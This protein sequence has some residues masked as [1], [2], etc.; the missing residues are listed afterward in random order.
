MIRTEILTLTQA[1]KQGLK[2]YFTGKPCKY[3][4]VARRYASNGLCLGCM[5]RKNA[6]RAAYKKQH[7]K[8]RAEHYRKIG[9]AY[10][11][12]RLEIQREYMAQYYQKHKEKWYE[13]GKKRREENR[14]RDRAYKKKWRDNNKEY[15]AHRSMLYAAKKGKATLKGLSKADFMPFYEMR[16]NMEKMTGVKHHVDH[17]VPINGKNVCG[18]HVPWN[19]QVIP[20]SENMRKSNRF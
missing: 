8:D 10:R 12:T 2:Y 14:E 3:G 6:E 18:L 7:K 13:W 5:Q 17:I 16:T 9:K 19:L 15:G 20:A 4:H 11:E 1:R